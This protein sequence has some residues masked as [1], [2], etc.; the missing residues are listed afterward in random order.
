MRAFF[1]NTD[2]TTLPIFDGEATITVKQELNAGDSKQ[3]QSSALRRM[4]PGSTDGNSTG[5]TYDVDFAVA[6]FAKV[7][8]Y[9][10][11]WTLVDAKGKPVA[12]DT[13]KLMTAALRELRPDVFAEIERVIDEFVLATGKKNLKADS[14]TKPEDI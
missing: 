3:M 1:T 14:A 11:D 12:I 5:V 8:T 4:I 9:L 13:P 7:M 6:A 10:V 2:T